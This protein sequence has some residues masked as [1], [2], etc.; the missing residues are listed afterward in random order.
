[1]TRPYQMVFTPEALQQMVERLQGESCMALDTEF[2]WESTYYAHFGLIQ[3]GLADGTCYLVD[4]LAIEDLSPLGKVLENPGITKILHDAVQDLML[5]RRTTGAVARSIFDTRLAAGFAGL[6]ST[7]SLAKLL[8]ELIGV[9]LEKAHTRADWTARPLA[10]EELD[11]AVDDVHYLPQVMQLIRERAREA[12]VESWMDEELSTLDSP[13]LTAEK[14]PEDAWLRIRVSPPL[15][16]QNLAALRELAAWREE[17]ARTINRPRKWILEDRELVSVAIRLPRKAEE[18]AECRHLNPQAAERKGKDLL[19]AVQRALALPES[20]WPS[21]PP[22]P[23]RDKQIKR[24]V[25]AAMQE[26]ETLAQKRKIDPALVCSRKELSL[27]LQQGGDAPPSDHALLQGWR[28][29][30]LGDVLVKYRPQS[31]F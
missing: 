19:A 20:E 13:A 14:L 18:L 23:S 1:M 30:L 3:I 31:L 27:F 15:A 7:L 6:P 8:S 9:E 11:Y 10:P 4:P 16:P 28:A 2:V 17:K 24:A 29:E 5:L 25:D 22:Q 21:P 12:G 26:I